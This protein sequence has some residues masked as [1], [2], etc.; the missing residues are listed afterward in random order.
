MNARKT[1]SS[2]HEKSHSVVS[3]GLVGVS[4]MTALK[5]GYLSKKSKGLGSQLG[6]AEKTK[7]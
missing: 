1:G 2:S 4:E 7:S 5:D 3:F 6:K